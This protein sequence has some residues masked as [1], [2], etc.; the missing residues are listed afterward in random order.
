MRGHAGRSNALVKFYNRTEGRPQGG[1]L[2]VSF[3]EGKRNG[4]T[5]ILYSFL[6]SHASGLSFKVL[7]LKLW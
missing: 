3:I 6:Q 1:V 7:G 2:Q 4:L 5:K